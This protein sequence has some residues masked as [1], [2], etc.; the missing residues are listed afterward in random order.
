MATEI[1]KLRMKART[2][3]SF[4]EAAQVK[5]A[6]VEWNDSHPQSKPLDLD[7]WDGR[8]ARLECCLL[9]LLGDAPGVDATAVDVMQ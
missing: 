3:E 2:A 5:I 6:R 1:Q 4:A 9:R 7:Y 8:T